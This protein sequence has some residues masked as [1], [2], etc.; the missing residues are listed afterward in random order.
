MHPYDIVKL[1]TFED[2]DQTSEVVDALT[3]A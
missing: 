2:H 1:L 3:R